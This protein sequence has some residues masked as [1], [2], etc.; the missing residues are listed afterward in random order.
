MNKVD[1]FKKEL[2]Y[3]KNKKYVLCLHYSAQKPS[4]EL[5]GYGLK[6]SPN[7]SHSFGEWKVIKEATT[8]ETGIKEHTCKEC[9]FEEN[10][11][12]EK[13]PEPTPSPS[14][15]ADNTNNATGQYKFLKE[16]IIE[17]GYDDDEGN[18]YIKCDY[19]VW[20]VRIYYLDKEAKF[21]FYYNL[22]DTG[23]LYTA[24]F[25]MPETGTN[26]VK[27]E[28]DNSGSVID[29]FANIN[30]ANYVKDADVSI[31]FTDSMM[32]KYEN[33]DSRKSFA[34]LWNKI[35]KA[36]F[37]G[38]SYLLTEKFMGHTTLGDFGFVEYSPPG[39]HIWSV[40]VVT[41]K[42]TEKKKGTE[43]YTCGICGVT[44][45]ETIPSGGRYR[46]T[47]NNIKNGNIVGG[48]VA[49]VK[50]YNKNCTKASI[51]K[52]VKIGGVTY[53]VTSI[54]KNAFKNCKNLKSITIG[55]N[56]TKIGKNSFKGCKKLKKITIKS[57]KISS[58]GSNA[59]NG[60]NKKAK[61]KVPK[62]KLDKYK[63]KIMKAKAPE[64]SSITKIK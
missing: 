31:T 11:I 43:V 51:P 37:A 27:I 47:K 24:S 12:I 18:K 61:F 35:L 7:H 57:S 58:I 3:V 6:L 36:A 22:D 15:I 46:I 4:E 50:P 40:C 17:N 14:N 45:T 9:G 19:D 62:K 55:Q 63:K 21:L 8:K 41:K 64:E 5:V 29:A 34:E 33:K 60:I 26:T 56:V 30:V 16:Y 42:A 25:E 10:E 1:V 59:F 28:F 44:K 52:T 23:D 32:N 20:N 38:W 2:S 13:L 54:D 39:K 53:K 48:T 49:Y